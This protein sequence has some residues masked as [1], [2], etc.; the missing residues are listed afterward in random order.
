MSPLP[1]PG[2]MFAH[3]ALRRHFTL[4]ELAEQAFNA[5]PSRDHAQA[6]DAAWM[7][8]VRHALNCGC[9]LT[10]PHIMGWIKK[11]LNT[12]A[13]SLGS[14]FDGVSTKLRAA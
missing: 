7:E 10:E 8:V 14:S 11:R 4:W 2:S 9:T 13:N 12:Y 6:A 5:E 1:A 3:D